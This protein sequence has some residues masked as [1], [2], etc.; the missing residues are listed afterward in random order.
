MDSGL[1]FR[2]ENIM[3][4]RENERRDGFKPYCNHS[5]IITLEPLRSL[6]IRKENDRCL[7]M[8]LSTYNEIS[9]RDRGACQDAGILHHCCS[10][11]A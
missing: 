10:Q 9:C 7:L 1:D 4:K 8:N 5:F 11:E 6:Y 3:E 2:G